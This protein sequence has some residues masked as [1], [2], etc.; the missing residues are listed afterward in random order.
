VYARTLIKQTAATTQNNYLLLMMRVLRFQLWITN[1][2]N[3]DAAT[4]A[5]LLE[6]DAV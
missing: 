2:A 4:A 1:K 3:V 5:C 6:V